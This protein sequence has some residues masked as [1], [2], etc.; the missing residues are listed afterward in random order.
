MRRTGEAV[1][2]TPVPNGETNGTGFLLPSSENQLLNRMT[3]AQLTKAISAL[4]EDER[5]R[6]LLKFSRNSK[7]KSPSVKPRPDAHL[8]DGL[9][10]WRRGVFGSKVTPNAVL[11]ERENSN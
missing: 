1:F 3:T 8:W 9:E 7:P 4:T 5:S 2:F 11:L 10:E 6:I